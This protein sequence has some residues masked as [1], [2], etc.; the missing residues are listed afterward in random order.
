MELISLPVSP[1]SARVRIAIYAKGL[2]VTIVAPPASWQGSAAY[3]TINPLGRVPTLI[4]DDGSTIPESDVILEY[5]EERFPDAERL[6]PRAPIDRASVRLIA[7]VVD[8]YLMPPLVAL[9]SPSLDEKRRKLN[10]SKLLDAL[11]VIDELLGEGPYTVD[12]RL[13]FADRALAPALFAVHVTGKRFEFDFLGGNENVQ[14]Y[15]AALQQNKYVERVLIE[16]AEGLRL[17][18]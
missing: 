14:G 3:R 2:N 9:A 15:A 11:V 7:R 5:L 4:C 6:L 8:L 18:S 17:I 12:D 10:I 13:T 16:M 1:Y